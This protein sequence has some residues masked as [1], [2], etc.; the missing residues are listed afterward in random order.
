MVKRQI[1]KKIIKKL[2]NVFQKYDNIVA[3]YIFGS[4]GTEQYNN[5]MSDIDFAVLFENK[6]NEEEIFIEL[7]EIFKTDNV[8]VLDLENIPIFLKYKIIKNG[9]LIYQNKEKSLDDFIENVLKF[10]FDEK[11]RFDQYYKDYE[12]L[13]KDKYAG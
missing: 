2:I 8:D 1:N 10:Y 9:N 3:V 12:K 13:L 5:N 6:K 7:T 11:Y 4:Y